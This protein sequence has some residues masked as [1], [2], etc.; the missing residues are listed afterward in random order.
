MILLTWGFR[1]SPDFSTCMII[2]TNRC[3]LDCNYCFFKRENQDQSL[4]PELVLERVKHFKNIV[5]TGGE[6]LLNFNWIKEFIL[7]AQ[8]KNIHFN[9]FMLFTNGTLLNQNKLDFLKKFDVDINISLDGPRFVHDANRVFPDGSGSFDKVM[10][11]VKLLQAEHYPFRITLVL[12]HKSINNLLNILL[13]LDKLAPENILISPLMESKNRFVSPLTSEEILSADN[14][15]WEYQQ[16]YFHKKV[17]TLLSSLSLVPFLAFE[18]KDI[19]NRRVKIFPCSSGL[20]S[21]TITTG[22]VVVPCPNAV[23]FDNVKYFNLKEK[24]F[25]ESEDFIRD[26]YA[27]FVGPLKKDFRE[28]S[29]TILSCPIKAHNYS[30]LYEE[31]LRTLRFLAEQFNNKLIDKFVNNKELV[32]SYYSK[33][34]GR[35]VD[36]YVDKVKIGNNIYK[37]MILI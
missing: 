10:R 4:T 32:K 14:Q 21:F 15:I 31:R 11:A 23:G 3:N 5:F 29:D 37:A 30:P 1:K 20:E 27:W 9:K 22:G 17:K 19:I 8:E 7:L 24:S 26:K 13:F 6:P 12:S 34:I 2:V 33:F 28:F 35:E 16:L 18:K 36:F 25:Y